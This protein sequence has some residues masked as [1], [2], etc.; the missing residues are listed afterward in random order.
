M[1]VIKKIALAGLLGVLGTVFYRFGRIVV[2]AV[3][4]KPAPRQPRAH[5]HA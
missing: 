2:R 3:R 5:K 1:T 4:E